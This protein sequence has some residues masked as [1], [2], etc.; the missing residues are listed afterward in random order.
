MPGITKRR[1]HLQAAREA[2][3]Q[4]NTTKIDEEVHWEVHGEAHWEGLTESEEESDV[5]F[6]DSDTDSSDG[7]KASPNRFGQ[8]GTWKYA[9]IAGTFPHKINIFRRGFLNSH[10]TA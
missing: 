2:K 8:E 5:E 10:S 9:D 7:S 1:R 6:S 3:R 4:K